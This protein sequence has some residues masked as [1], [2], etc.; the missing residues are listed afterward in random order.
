M[1]IFWTVLDFFGVQRERKMCVF[2]GESFLI[3]FLSV[4]TDVVTDIV[5]DVVAD[6]VTDIVVCPSKVYSI[7]GFKAYSGLKLTSQ[8]PPEADHTQKP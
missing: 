4:V 8:T 6:I 2:N 1:E 7:L 3:D 5:T